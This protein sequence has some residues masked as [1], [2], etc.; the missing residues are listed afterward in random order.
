[1]KKLFISLIAVLFISSC[2]LV[3]FEDDINKNPNLPS[4]AT[5]SQLLANAMLYL[6]DLSSSQTGV[7]MVQ[8]LSETQYVDASLYPVGGTSFY[9]IYE[10]PLINLQTV[11]NNSENANEVAAAKILKAYYFWH[12]TDRWGAVPFSE[13]LQGIEDFTP[14]YDSQQSI[15]NDLFVMLEE[16]VSQINTSGTLESDIM[17]GGDMEKWVKF[18]NTVR[19]LMALRLSEVDPATGQQEFVEALNG[20]IM[21]SNEDN[22]VFQHLANANNSNYWYEQIVEPPIREWWALSEGLVQLMRPVNDPRLPVYGDT[23]GAVT[24]KIEN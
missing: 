12:I 20:G 2:D 13:A 23:K 19:L 6:P 14:V 3:S 16:A 11:I 4:E 10:D 22:F 21:E 8:H 24:E 7:I 1:M 5:P 17:Y 15:Y 9:W 18:G